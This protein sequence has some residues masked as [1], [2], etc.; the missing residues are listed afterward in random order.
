MP[1]APGKAKFDFTNNILILSENI[2]VLEPRV[3]CSVLVA[4]RIS[5]QSVYLFCAIRFCRVNVLKVVT[6]ES[7]NNQQQQ[8]YS[9]ESLQELYARFSEGQ[10]CY[11][12]SQDQQREL[13]RHQHLLQQQQQQVESEHHHQPQ[14]PPGDESSSEESGED[15]NG[16]TINENEPPAS[17]NNPK[18]TRKKRTRDRTQLE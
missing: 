16:A 13:L 18:K 4:D 14:Q 12:Q 15:E 17:V 7:N 11:I 1:V 8:Y 3:E 2:A 5:H 6:M 9:P 10:V